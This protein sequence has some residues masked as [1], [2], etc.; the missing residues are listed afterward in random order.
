MSNLT[1]LLIG[2]SVLVLM[3]FGFTGC[4][5]IDAGH[6]GVKVNL[7]GDGKGV[8]DVT[9]VTGWVV[10]NPIS[11]KIIEFPTYVQHK[12]YKKTFRIRS[13]ACTSSRPSTRCRCSR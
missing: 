6:V 11:T 9:E 2:V 7:Y 8:D 10:Y 12:E 3:I 5:R 1:K 13:W 4:E